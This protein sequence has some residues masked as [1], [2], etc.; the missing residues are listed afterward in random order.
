MEKSKRDVRDKTPLKID[1][2]SI[3]WYAMRDLKRSNA[4][5]PAYKMLGDIGF[6]VF[7]PFKDKYVISNGTRKVI[8]V[9]VFFD[10][11]FVRGKKKELDCIAE[12]TATLQYRYVKGG[13]YKQATIIR[14][15]DMERFINAVRTADSPKFYLPE[16]ITS[17]MIGK[18]VIVHGGPLD[19]YEVPLRKMRGSKIK[20]AFVSLSKFVTTEVE[21]KTFDYLEYV[22]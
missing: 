4:K 11:L 1:D 17:D 19:G 18:T 8:K 13:Y 16:E 10:L 15:R 9:P 21:L 14:D 2:D 7:T 5:E 20:R 12:N 6:E 22:K 3:Y